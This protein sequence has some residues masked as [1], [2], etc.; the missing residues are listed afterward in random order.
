M[1]LLIL[2]ASV[3]AAAQSAWRAG[4]ETVA[5]DLFA[6]R[7]LTGPYPARR[8]DPASY[9]HGL[10]RLAAEAA[11]GPWMYTGAME[12]HPEL[13]DRIGET[14]P[15]WG[16]SGA[17]LRAVRDPGAVSSELARRGLPAPE[18]RATADGLP[19]DGSWLV[20]PLASAGGRRIEALEGGAVTPRWPVT[21]QRRIDGESLAALFVGPELVGVTRQILGREG[22]PF[23]YV[24]SLG[25]WPVQAQVRGR[26]E[27]I[28][29]A[30]VD[31]FA[32]RGLFGV[33]LILD[34]DG[35]P[36]PV[37]VNPRYTASAEVLE[38]ASGRPLLVD[39]LRSFG[40]DVPETRRSRA[41]PPAFVGKRIL[42]ADRR[43]TLPAVDTWRPR[44][45]VSGSF[46]VPALADIPAE[47][48]VFEPGDPVLT[49]LARG[50]T[51]ESCALSLDRRLSRW[52]KRLREA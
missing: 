5:I 13:I 10:E 48:M 37:E 9:P 4:L 1:P 21:Y 26:I 17:T 39:H 16:I 29:A 23:A 11:P 14:R 22:E 27:A 34:R 28:G 36:Y 7:D 24:G 51:L 44:P 30:L 33:D 40:G 19:R 49:V 41:R 38:L 45:G 20:K 35:F 42:F 50:R 25:P 32:L 12:N 52:R 18:V 8:I 15:L 3:R 2:G 31:E 47:G 6:D 46:A 43:S